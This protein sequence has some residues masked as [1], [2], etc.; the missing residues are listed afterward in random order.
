VTVRR[1]EDDVDH[2]LATGDFDPAHLPALPAS[3]GLPAGVQTGASPRGWERTTWRVNVPADVGRLFRA[4]LCT[5]QRRI[6]RAF[7]RSSTPGEALEAMF[8]HTIDELRRRAGLPPREH[9]VFERDGWR[10]MRAMPLGTFTAGDVI[11]GA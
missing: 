2:A 5:V 1:L 10:V 3:L 8:D 4:A 6:E 11:C 9:L 7:G